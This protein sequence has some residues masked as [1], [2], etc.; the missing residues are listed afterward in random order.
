LLVVQAVVVEAV[1]LEV[2]EQAQAH[3]VEAVQQ[4]VSYL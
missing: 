1:V 2:T 4:K 3:L